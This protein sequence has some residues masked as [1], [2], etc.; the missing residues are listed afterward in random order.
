MK[1]WWLSQLT[2]LTTKAL[3]NSSAADYKENKCV[4]AT[5]SDGEANTRTES[6]DYDGFFMWSLV[7]SNTQG[8]Q[9]EF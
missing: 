2:S 1:I 6:T 9:S 8:M 7:G 4:V 3:M 5:E